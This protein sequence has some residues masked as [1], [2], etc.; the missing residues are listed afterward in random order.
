MAK[1][2]IASGLLTPQVAALACAK[3]VN[4]EWQ[5]LGVV[6]AARADLMPHCGPINGRRVWSLKDSKADGSA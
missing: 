6:R 3:P 2:L 1:L 5:R 4:P